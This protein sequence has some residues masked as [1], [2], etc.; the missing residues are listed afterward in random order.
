MSELTGLFLGAG[1][2]YEAGMPLVWELTRELKAWL[3]PEKLRELNR[4]W[5]QQGGGHP[6]NGIGDFVS[7]LGRSDYVGKARRRQR[8]GGQCRDVATLS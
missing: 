1:A 4:G 2:S 3:T 5:R 7:L 6:D 8:A